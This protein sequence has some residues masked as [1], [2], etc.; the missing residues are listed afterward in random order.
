MTLLQISQTAHEMSSNAQRMLLQL[1]FLKNV[2]NRETRCARDGIAAERA[3]KFH[4]I[5][6]C[7]CDLLRGDHR[8][9]RK[10]V[11]N[12]LAK[13]HDVGNHSL[14]F[15]SPEVRAQASK[16]H[17][18]FVGDADAARGTDVTIDHR[19]ITGRKYD[20]PPDAGHCLRNICGDAASLGLYGRKNLLNMPRIP[21]S[22]FAVIAAIQAAIVVGEWRD[23]HPWLFPVSAGSVKFVGL[24]SIN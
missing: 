23:V 18:D 19:K 7:I 3:E 8:G 14:C 2:Q 9:E 12:G 22:G 6:E 11:A 5:I 24:M 13:N 15:K 10:R 21:C 1:F 17:L 16:S 4:A 20:L